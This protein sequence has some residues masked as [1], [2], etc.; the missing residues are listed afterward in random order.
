MPLM[1]PPSELSYRFEPHGQFLLRGG[2]SVHGD[3]DDVGVL[4]GEEVYPGWCGL[5]GTGRV[6]YRV[7]N[8]PS[9][10]GLI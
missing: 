3:H 5:G 10:P 7:L 9:A 8:Q 4:G 6:L 2:V 1:G